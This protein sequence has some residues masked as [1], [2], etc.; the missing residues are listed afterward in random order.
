MGKSSRKTLKTLILAEN[1][2]D[3]N[4]MLAENLKTSMLVTNIESC[5]VDFHLP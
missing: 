5:H 2:E 3:I 4:I 1:I